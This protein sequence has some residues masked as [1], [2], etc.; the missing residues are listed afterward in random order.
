MKIENSAGNQQCQVIQGVVSWVD[1]IKQAYGSRK[2]S[3]AAI[4]KPQDLYQLEDNWL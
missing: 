1:T 4:F 2:F 3:S